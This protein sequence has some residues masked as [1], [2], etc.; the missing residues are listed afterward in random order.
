MQRFTFGKRKIDFV[1]VNHSLA[2]RYSDSSGAPELVIAVL[3]L[4]PGKTPE[5]GIQRLFAVRTNK[6]LAAQCVLTPYE[7]KIRFRLA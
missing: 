3:D 2:Q 5:Q 1:S 4:L 7:A 6:K